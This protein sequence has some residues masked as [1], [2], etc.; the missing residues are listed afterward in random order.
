[1]TPELEIRELDKTDKEEVVEMTSDI[2]DGRDYIPDYFDRWI[3][4][5]GFICGTVD[6]EIVALAKHTWHSDDIL[7]LEG[8]RVHPDH[9][10]KGYGRSMIEG[11]V[12]YIDE[13]LDYR[14]ARFLTSDDNTPV[15][16]VV[17]DIGFGLKQKY[18]YVRIDDEDLEEMDPPS[19]DEVERV[20]IEKQADE[21]I[22]KVLSSK[23]LE[24]NVGLYMEHWT[25]YPVEED[26]IQDRVEN[27]HCYSV[28]EEDTGKI[29]AL[30]FM[31]V[32]DIYESLSVTFACG[33]HEGMKELFRY[34][35]KY[36]LEEGYERLRLKSASDNVIEAAKEV[37]FSY[38]DHHNCTLVYEYDKE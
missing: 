18:D 9:R 38:S 6:D 33:T 27:G 8:L 16:K 36:C 11:Q 15:K 5:G 35:L 17:E 28:K 23:E 12:D 29:E 1:M 2:W 13:H 7:W 22:D 3:E 25:A 26:L 37:G 24:D 21:V 32:H 14:V 19:D 4:D 34:G 20:Q 31:Q 30:M 10:E